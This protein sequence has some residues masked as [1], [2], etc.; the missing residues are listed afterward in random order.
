M[1]RCHGSKEERASQIIIIS[2]KG[3]VIVFIEV[4]I[5]VYIADKIYQRLLIINW[6]IN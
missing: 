3:I 6:T 2:S 4:Y 5:V 1:E